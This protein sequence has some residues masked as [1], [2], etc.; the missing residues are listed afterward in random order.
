[1]RYY[2]FP[3]V[4]CGRIVY[5][6]ELSNPKASIVFCNEGFHPVICLIEAGMKMLKKYL[7]RMNDVGK[8]MGKGLSCW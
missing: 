4:R 3:S 2:A 5:D 8:G 1:M 6:D 7:R